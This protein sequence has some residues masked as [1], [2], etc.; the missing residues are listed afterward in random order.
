M[1]ARVRH[2]L[3]RIVIVA[4]IYCVIGVATSF[5]SGAAGSASLRTAWRLVAWALSLVTFGGQIIYERLRLRAGSVS[6]ALRTCAAVA[7]AALVLAVVGPV[8]TH[9]GMADQ[10][11]AALLSVV[12]WP[13]ATAVP[14]FLVA[15]AGGTLI[16]R[17]PET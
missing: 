15:L 11:Q 3:R 1:E 4:L 12:V 9:W 10:W 5:L 17:R 14:A 2:T 13:I 6:A 7:L 8:R 16:G